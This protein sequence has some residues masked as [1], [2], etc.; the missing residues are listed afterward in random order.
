MVLKIFLVVT[1]WCLSTPKTVHR[2]WVLEKLEGNVTVG[3]LIRTLFF[4]TRYI[5]LNRYNL[6]RLTGVDVR[7]SVTPYQLEKERGRYSLLKV[8]YRRGFGTVQRS[9]P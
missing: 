4:G 3:W 8:P 2:F 1:F 5:E 7:P 6:L 9:V